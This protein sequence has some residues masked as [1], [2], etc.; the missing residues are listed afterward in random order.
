MKHSLAVLSA[1]QAL[2]AC[3]ALMPAVVPAAQLEEPPPIGKPAMKAY[4]QILPDGR[5]VYSDKPVKGARIDETIEVDPPINGNTWSTVPGTP[6]RIPPQTKPT[7]VNRVATIPQ[8]GKKKTLDD[9]DAD[10]TRAE[11]LLEEARKRQE[12][13]V[14][15]LPGERTGNANGTSRLNEAYKARQQSLAKAVDD[16]QTALKKSIAEREALKSSR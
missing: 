1:R 7:P 3:C 5:V 13:G 15:P 6:P 14:E 11:M 9:A 2:L 12:S 10:V 16:A 4:R 8:P